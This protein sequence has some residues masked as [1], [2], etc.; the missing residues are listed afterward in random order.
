MIRNPRTQRSRQPHL[1]DAVSDALGELEFFCLLQFFMAD[2]RD[3]FVLCSVQ[4]QIPSVTLRDNLM[5][6]TLRG[7]D[8][9]ASHQQHRD[10]D[11]NQ[12]QADHKYIPS[13]EDAR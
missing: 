12:H 11:V 9:S 6:M 5:V 4:K 2:C 3:E 8:N 10:D 7:G 13:K 1:E